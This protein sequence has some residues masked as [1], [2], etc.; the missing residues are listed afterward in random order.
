MDSVQ[1]N[2]KSNWINV[3]VV[4]MW[5]RKGVGVRPS[6]SRHRISVM[7]DIGNR[8]GGK[9]CWCSV[10]SGR[11]ELRVGVRWRSRD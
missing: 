10:R 7:D 1:G 2:E 9:R 11:G 4:S 8:G 6:D 3:V 5:F